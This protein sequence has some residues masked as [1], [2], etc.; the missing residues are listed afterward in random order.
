MSRLKDMHPADREGLLL[1]IP[2]AVLILF[3]GLTLLIATGHRN[4]AVGVCVGI[5]CA[6][7]AGD[8]LLAVWAGKSVAAKVAAHRG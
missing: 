8:A 6:S 2:C 5:V 3:S 7:F 4:I 1:L